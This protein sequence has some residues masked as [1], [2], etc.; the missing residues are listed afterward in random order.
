MVFNRDTFPVVNV[1]EDQNVTWIPV[2]FHHLWRSKYTTSERRR[3]KPHDF[4][5]EI[6]VSVDSM[7]PHEL[8]CTDHNY[9]Y[10]EELL[11]P[12]EREVVTKVPVYYIKV[13]ARG[14]EDIV[15]VEQQKLRQLPMILLKAVKNMCGRRLSKLTAREWLKVDLGLLFPDIFPEYVRIA[16]KVLEVANRLEEEGFKDV[17]KPPYLIKGYEVVEEEKKSSEIVF[18]RVMNTEKIF[19][20]ADAFQDVIASAVDEVIDRLIDEFITEEY[21]MPIALE[22]KEETEGGYERIEA[23][24]RLGT[25]GTVTAKVTSTKPIE[26]NTKVANAVFRRS[27]SSTVAPGNYIYWSDELYSFL[28]ANTNEIVNAIVEAYENHINKMFYGGE[29]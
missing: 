6:E 10:Y 26:E 2:R 3:S 16:N 13:S 28:V 19:E 5:I 20:S 12:T 14:G 18:E 22:F 23:E 21:N 27:N 17:T 25:K 11:T 8:T 29:E 9:V 1:R 24:C 4:W 7:L 15:T